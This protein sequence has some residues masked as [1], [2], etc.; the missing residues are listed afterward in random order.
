V[1]D[2]LPV[3]LVPGLSPQHWPTAEAT[4]HRS[5]VGVLMRLALAQ[6]AAAR[7][8][9]DFA[10]ADAIRRHLADLGITIQDA[11]GESRWEFSP[12]AHV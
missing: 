2:N 9:K 7:A 6:R 5:V 1:H 11:E 10:A 4:G 3:T 12:A 8:R